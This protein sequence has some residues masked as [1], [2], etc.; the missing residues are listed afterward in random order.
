M[1]LKNPS[2]THSVA[3]GGRLLSLWEAGPPYELDPSTLATRPGPATLGGLVTPG[4]APSTTGHAGLDAA[5]RLG[6]ALTAHP[7]V[8]PPPRCVAAGWDGPGG[9][10]TTDPVT[11]RRLC[12]WAWRSRLRLG[13]GG[14]TPEIHVDLAEFDGAWR[15]VGCAG[16][17]L[18]GAAFN[19][20]DAAVSLGATVFFQTAT[21]FN[22]APYILGL[23]GPAQCVHIDG[24]APMLVHVVPRPAGPGE[25]A[26]EGGGG[27]GGVSSSSSPIT[28]TADEA[29]FLVHHANAFEV[30]GSRG[31]R[32][33]VWSSGWGPEAL[34]ALASGG[35]KGSGMLGSWSVVLEGSFSAIPYST[36]MQHTLDLDAGTVTRTTLYDATAM[37]HPKVNPAFA[38]RPTRFVWFTA[39]APGANPPGVS[40]PPQ[41]IVKLDT[42]TGGTQVWSP[43]PR[44]FV[45]EIVF[46]PADTAGGG[47]AGAE[48]DGWLAAMTF[49]AA[50]KTSSLVILD[51]A[52]VASGPIARVRLS[53]AVPHGLHGDWTD[54]VYGPGSEVAYA[55]SD[56]EEEES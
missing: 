5:L 1:R 43:G 45:E 25:K 47:A 56:V 42:L 23:A 7:H 38:S 9:D 10:A 52:D 20:H 46:V 37:E 22:P 54:V 44:V 48:D 36:L 17:T 26:A 33:A 51:A 14:L 2:N 49:D 11:D 6:S 39:A 35:A 15:R 13:A 24:S 41:S 4:A 40:G 19:P 16:L 28:L 30:P 31:R 27:S 32:I 53:H 3:W 55:P 50:T 29:S 12:T 21:S 8:A 18:P 34:A